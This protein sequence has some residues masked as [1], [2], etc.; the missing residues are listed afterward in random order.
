MPI[1]KV[2]PHEEICPNGAEFQVES[3]KTYAKAC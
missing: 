2:L 1:I 3:S